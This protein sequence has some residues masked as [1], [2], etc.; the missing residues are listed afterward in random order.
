MKPTPPPPGFPARFPSLFSLPSATP[1]GP[2][3]PRAPPRFPPV[4]ALQ[5][6]TPAVPYPAG[7]PVPFPPWGM[8]PVPPLGGPQ[9]PPAGFWGGVGGLL[10]AV[11]EP[12]LTAR[13]GWW[14]GG[15]AFGAL[16]LLA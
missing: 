1:P 16:P 7:A 12:R 14:Q 6:P 11:P 4:V 10:L 2:Y 5:G 13:L 3:A 15:L 8:M 9:A